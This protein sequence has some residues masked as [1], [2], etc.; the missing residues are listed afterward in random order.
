VV[1]LA[2]ELET[3]QQVSILKGAGQNPQTTG[4]STYHIKADMNVLLHLH[5]SA[6]QHTNKTN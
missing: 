2:H 1:A 4:I 6:L 3:L 5:V